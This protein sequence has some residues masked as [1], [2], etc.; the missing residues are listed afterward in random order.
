MLSEIYEDFLK[1]LPQG[2]DIDLEK[3]SGSF[4]IEALLEYIGNSLSDNGS[5]IIKTVLRF[6]AISLIFALTE[7]IVC[8]GGDISASV[9]SA[10]GVC[11]S[12]P[13]MIFAKDIIISVKDGLSSGSDFFAGIIPTVSTVL[14]IGNGAATASSTVAGMSLSLSFVSGF[15]SENLFSA[16]VLIF[17]TSLISFY[18]TGGNISL[19]SR[20]VRSWFNYG[21]GIVSL[22]I[23]ATLSFQTLIS[24]S[25]DSLTLRGAKYAVSNM[26]PIVGNVVSGALSTLASGVKMLSSGV[27]A[28]SVACILYFMGAP[29]LS[30]LI[31][32]FCIGACITLCSFAGAAFGQR[33]FESLKGSIDCMVGIVASSLL[34]YVLN[35]IVFMSVT[36]GG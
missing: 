28:L 17:L 31:Y 9:R 19:V 22:I 15:L 1:L 36:P 3:L 12:V 26:I 34:V 13:V 14:A 29:L 33:F 23:V 24:A 21:I 35:V 11:L 6:F 18:D 16:S 10:V 30:L 4:G 32:R 5:L 25:A 2:L 8:D 20:G 27:G 7:L